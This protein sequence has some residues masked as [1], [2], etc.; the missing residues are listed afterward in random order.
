MQTSGQ[1][2]VCTQ[3][4]QNPTQSQSHFQSEIYKIYV[5]ITFIMTVICWNFVGGCAIG[6]ASLFK[7]YK[8][9]EQTDEKV[10]QSVMQQEL[11]ISTIKIEVEKEFRNKG[12]HRVAKPKQAELEISDN[13]NAEM[14]DQSEISLRLGNDSINHI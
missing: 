1:S 9:R 14:I 12:R 2:K 8:K 11:K 10:N 3:N 6:I 5:L 4:V 7:N 13:R